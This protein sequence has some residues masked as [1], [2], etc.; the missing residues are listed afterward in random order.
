MNFLKDEFLPN[1]KDVRLNFKEKFNE[2]RKN[3]LLKEG[4][5]IYK[6]SNLLMNIYKIQKT[7][8]KAI[9]IFSSSLTLEKESLLQSF[10]HLLCP[11]VTDILSNLTPE[12]AE[13]LEKKESDKFMQKI[14]A[15]LKESE[16]IIKHES[17]NQI[18]NY[19]VFYYDIVSIDLTDKNVSLPFNHYKEIAKNFNLED[20][21]V[22]D[23][24]KAIIR[25]F[26]KIYVKNEDCSRLYNPPTSV[27]SYSAIVGPSFMGK[28]QFSFVLARMMPV[29]YFNFTNDRG[30]QSVYRPFHH[31]RKILVELIPMDIIS[32]DSSTDSTIIFDKVNAKLFTIGLIWELIQYSLKFQGNYSNC[33]W[34]EHYLASRRIAFEPLSLKEFYNLIG[35]DKL[36]YLFY[37]IV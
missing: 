3:K 2:I 23:T 31:F 30:I 19:Y 15:F 10:Y 36:R 12:L 16:S 7:T 1:L 37:N 9:D 32:L 22:L 27:S 33:E 5:D 18:L 6:V 26:A 20:T 17:Y 24:V 34:F 4:D 13:Y 28:T 35:N 25:P 21:V 8:A 11:F 14:K 29:F